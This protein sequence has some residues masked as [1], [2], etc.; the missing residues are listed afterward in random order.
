MLFYCARKGTRTPMR[1]LSLAPETS[2]STSSAIRAII[3]K[4]NQRLFQKGHFEPVSESYVSTL[5]GNENLKQVQVDIIELIR[6]PHCKI[7]LN[8]EKI[9]ISPT[10][11]PSPSF[12][13]YSI[14]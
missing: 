5:K 11:F 14:S 2:A 12:T 3:P 4:Q 10:T 6:Q 8:E 7:N 9:L 1:L 13:N